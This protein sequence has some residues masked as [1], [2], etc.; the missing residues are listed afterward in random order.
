[1]QSSSAASS[2]KSVQLPDIKKA[3]QPP[4]VTITLF[5]YFS[6]LQRG[7]YY[8]RIFN[9]LPIFW[10]TAQHIVLSTFTCE[11]KDST[12]DEILSEIFLISPLNSGSK[13]NTFAGIII[14]LSLICS[15]YNYSTILYYKFKKT[16]PRWSV[17]F[18]A[19]NSHV[20]LPLLFLP[21]SFIL[22]A[23]VAFY[24]DEEKKYFIAFIVLGLFAYMLEVLDLYLTTTLSA[25]TVFF[26]DTPALYYD[27]HVVFFSLLLNSFLAILEWLAK[28]CGTGFDYLISILQIIVAVYMIV[29]MFD[30]PFAGIFTNASICS[31]FPAQIA[32][33]LIF[34]INENS[35][36]PLRIL[37]AVFVYI[38]SMPTF[39]FIFSSRSKK[40]IQEEEF[41]TPAKAIRQLRV[42][43]SASATS[44]TNGKL[45]ETITS[46]CNDNA[47]RLEVAKF[48]CFFHEFQPQFTAQLAMLRSATGLS[49]GNQYLMSQLK[50]A[51]TSRQ[52]LAAVDE[53]I[54]LRDQTK[55]IEM[56]I[57]A[58]WKYMELNNDF[59][60]Y[61]IIESINV[62]L[63]HCNSRWRE[64]I[65][66]YPK[67]ALLA[68][69]Y[70][71]FLI[72]C[73]SDFEAA[74]EW[75]YKALQLQ[76]GKVY[77]YDVAT[78]HFL[79]D[80]PEYA[81]KIINEKQLASIDDVDV[82]LKDDS[83]SQLIDQPRMRL[84]YQRAI[85]NHVPTVI[86][87]IFGLDILRFAA[88]LAF[89][90]YVAS[91]F[92]SS[93]DIC[94]TN[95]GFIRNVTDLGERAALIMTEFVFKAAEVQGSILS[96]EEM[97]EI[98]GQDSVEHTSCL[99][100]DSIDYFK[101][102]S[103]ESYDAIVSLNAI[104]NSMISA[105]NNGKDMDIPLDYLTAD[106]YELEFVN[107][108]FASTPGYN[109]SLLHI[110]SIFFQLSKQVSG[111]D[112]SWITS[113]VPFEGFGEA[114]IIIDNIYNLAE[115]F[116]NNTA[117]LKSNNTK[118]YVAL[119]ATII[120]VVLFVFIS[121]TLLCVLRINIKKT[122]A[123]CKSFSPEAFE[124]MSTNIF[125][126]DIGTDAPKFTTQIS[127]TSQSSAKTIVLGSLETFFT[128]VGIVFMILYCYAIFDL[129]D[130]YKQMSKVLLYASKRE[131]TAI[132]ALYS[133]VC[134]NII[135]GLMGSEMTTKYMLRASEA[136]LA[137]SDSHQYCATG[138]Y[139]EIYDDEINK[140]RT[141]DKCTYSSNSSEHQKYACVCLDSA[142]PIY[143]NMMTKL[144]VHAYSS[145]FV[146]SSSFVSAYHFINYHLY[147]SM[148]EVVQLILKAGEEKSSNA[149]TEMI[150]LSS[151]GIVI[152]IVTFGITAYMGYFLL[153]NYKALLR[154]ILRAPPIDAVANDDL[155]RI[156]LNRKTCKL[157]ANMSDIGLIVNQSN[158][159]TIFT[160]DDGIIISVNQ[161]FL[162]SFNFEVSH[163]IG[164]SISSLANIEDLESVYEVARSK[165]TNE[166]EKLE[167]L[168][169]KWMK[170]NGQSI[171]C[172]A[173]P[174][175]TGKPSERLVCF[176][177][178]DMTAFLSKKKRSDE[179]KKE[180]DALISLMF[181]KI[182]E[183]KKEIHIQNA[184]LCTIK[185]IQYGIDLAPTEI[186]KQ[187]ETVLLKL[188]EVTSKYEQIESIG[189]VQGMYITVSSTQGA[190]SI[191]VNCFHDL[192]NSFEDPTFFGE[193][194]VGIDTG[195]SI[196]VFL[197]EGDNPHYVVTGKPMKNASRLCRIGD[198]GHVCI[199]ESVYNQIAGIK[200]KFNEKHDEMIGKYYSVEPTDENQ[201]V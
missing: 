12:L 181:P 121:M 14:G 75:H 57:R 123:A 176:I 50:V 200:G 172:V 143:I 191:F 193:V 135:G 100:N 47:V 80:F 81:S 71:H 149:D 90:I 164:Q 86:N 49:F 114:S 105:I 194:T 195:E 131:C 103:S 201:Q 101:S 108:S 43:V 88:F 45:I 129:N 188:Y 28:F 159:P 148:D 177:L 167:K 187:R 59:S 33:C 65:D 141:V 54:P 41:T 79:H 165:E 169:I 67:N 116:I 51:E 134:A 168:Q 161:S 99:I 32:G 53:L 73:M 27:S 44:F 171:S 61:G 23:S 46:N 119:A 55:S 10:I 89:W 127:R 158:H 37:V 142:V 40:I 92:P 1:M 189:F 150:I 8:S 63:M 128:L 18:A 180:N 155:M 166:H 60:A 84:E 2:Q 13:F 66:K 130:K 174:V 39:Y 3:V 154:L 97:E 102:V 190:A 170:E 5:P 52:P 175:V 183:D 145:S 146:N 96:A 153:M 110:M 30:F 78:I 24:F 72:E 196:D 199:S 11:Y 140:I 178:T 106:E 163:I 197:T 26:H 137:F 36:R 107:S 122:V 4:T 179:L 6:L 48:V 7:F 25:H 21:V 124:K 186:M 182:I 29:K 132:E 15:I 139:G 115:S 157:A 144:I 68:E 62:Q 156:L 173:L 87:A 56:S 77:N 22:G 34:I 184:T 20:I 42:A 104:I 113:P 93:Y 31:V 111:M 112:S 76:D 38:V 83:L 198:P 118:G 117:I 58:A 9:Y 64:A 82:K 120:F 70:A 109:V 138:Y 160:T 19:F 152:A 69:E 95:M 17:G 151:I 91:S 35:F 126:A 192:L 16:L 98:I 162:I 147:D 133:V 94:V 125:L 85:S 136:V 74:S 185:L